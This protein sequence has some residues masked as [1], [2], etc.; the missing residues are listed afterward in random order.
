M[1]E[2]LRE[3]Q[4]IEEEARGMTERGDAKDGE[5]RQGKE[6]IRKGGGVWEGKY[7]KKNQKKVK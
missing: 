6:T 7:K 1:K 5:T 4:D 2:T 3:G